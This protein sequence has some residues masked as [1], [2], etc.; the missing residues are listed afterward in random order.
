MKPFGRAL[1]AYFGGDK[2]TELLLRRDDGQEN[3]VPVSL[4]FRDQPGFTPIDNAAIENCRGHVLDVGAGTGLHSLAL[5][6][7]RLSVTAIDI[8]PEAVRIM[9]QRG[10][11]D[12]HCADIFEFRTSRFDTVLMMG[13]GIG[14]VETIAG[15]DRFLTHAHELVTANGQLLFDSFDVRC[16]D[17]PSNLTYQEANRKAGRYVGEIRMQ[18]EFQGRE[19][20]YFGWLHVDAETLNDHA[21]SAGWGCEIVHRCKTGD[22]LVRLIR[23]SQ[24]SE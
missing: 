4:F 24:V 17:D 13:H 2:K 9:K 10:L 12:V 11:S 20:P 22:Y 6:H 5:Q 21:E 8:N 1:L 7:R 14:I 15:L 16:T 18:F 3:S 23:S 19:S